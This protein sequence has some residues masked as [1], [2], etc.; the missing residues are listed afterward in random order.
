[1]DKSAK[2]LADQAR[3]LAR[4]AYYSN[5]VASQEKAALHA[6]QSALGEELQL[7]CA[8][9]GCRTLEDAVAVVEI[10]ERFGRK[11]VRAITKEKS[12]ADEINALKGQMEILLKEWTEEKE[13]RLQWKS[14]RGGRN[15]GREN[16]ICY[17][18][19]E[20]GHYR[21]ECPKEPT[22]QENGKQV[23]SQ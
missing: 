23:S 15:K 6:F 13:R 5:N 8:E 12:T 22:T 19:Q 4:R 1:M 14:N 18:C 20:K 7:K 17:N 2:E 3:S 9:R 16:V 11:L 10:Q 21:R